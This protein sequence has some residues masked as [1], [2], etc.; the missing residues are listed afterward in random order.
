MTTHKRRLS[1]LVGAMLALLM[2]GGCARELVATYA[3][4]FGA[5]WILGSQTAPTTS[6]TQCFR[7]GELID[8]AELPQ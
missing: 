5:G 8:C 3:A 6:Q 2:T 1:V 4:T 7:N